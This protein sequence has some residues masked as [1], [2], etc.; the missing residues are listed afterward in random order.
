MCY[1]SL[2]LHTLG[3]GT[4]AQVT[5]GDLTRLRAYALRNGTGLKLILV[6][7]TSSAL[8]TSVQLGQTYTSG[9]TVAL[10]APSLSSKTGSLFGG[11]F[12]GKNGTFAGTT[13]NP[14]TVNGSSLTLNLPAASATVVT[15][16]A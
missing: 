5:G 4:F 9:N 13:P 16:D 15:L 8:S 11:H 7:V 1:S 12:V 3:T 2:L 6:N 14:L 10:T